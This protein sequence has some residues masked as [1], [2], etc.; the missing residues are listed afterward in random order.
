MESDKESAAKGQYFTQRIF[1]SIASYR[2]PETPSTLADLYAKAAN[3]MRLVCG[4]LWQVVPGEDDDCLIL[5]DAVPAG[6]VK[7][8]IVHPKD[9]FGA[10]W[11]RSVILSE[12]RGDEEFVLQIDSHMR[13]VE[14]WDEKLLAIWH[15]CKS[16][17]ALLSTYPVAYTPPDTLGAKAITILCPRQFNHRGILTFGARSEGYD[18]RPSSPIPNAFVSAGFLF[19]PAQAFDEVPYDPYL[20]FH[21]EEISLAARFWTHG[22]DAYSPNDVV[23]FHYYGNSEQRPRHWS[24]NPAWSG[25]DERS[26]SRLRHLFGIEPST[27]PKVLE[28]LD[29][30]AL[31]AARTIKEYESYADVDLCKQRIGGRG[32]SGH[33]PPHPE[34]ECLAR[35]RVFQQIYEKNVWS[36]DETRSGPGATRSATRGLTSFLKSFFHEN[37]IAALLD[38][39]CGDVNWIFQATGC[40]EFYFGIDL[41]KEMVCQNMALHSHRKGHFF[42]VGDICRD[43]LPKVDAVICRHVLTHQTSEQILMAI[44]NFLKSGARWL[45]ATG[46]DHAENC[47]TSPGYWRKIDLTRP[48]FNLPQPVQRIKDGNGCWLGIWR[49]DSLPKLG[50]SRVST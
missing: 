1:V 15:N 27:D 7:G 39:G 36:S 47:D 10:C 45:L 2:D 9:S 46:Y 35:V 12:L 43:A 3:P 44:N 8:K 29:K 33:Y 21:G 48:P 50:H 17:R 11:A 26:L 4:V 22:W 28:N 32:W 6:Q 5:H 42:G 19:G 41:V 16:P 34:P 18:I 38:A 20:Y 49:L 23:I 37:N 30:Y 14:G 40:L 31:G 25:L 24:D 13:F